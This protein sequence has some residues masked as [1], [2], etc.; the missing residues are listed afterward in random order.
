MIYS[1]T[2]KLRNI[3]VLIAAMIV[4]SQLNSEDT[5]EMPELKPESQTGTAVPTAD[6]AGPLSPPSLKQQTPVTP[7]SPVKKKRGW[8]KGRPRGKGANKSDTPNVS[9][10][11]E[12]PV[13]IMTCF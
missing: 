2:P 4:R 6:V 8:V 1:I 11:E 12:Q 9:S 7:E 10:Q 5:C 13:N 3:S